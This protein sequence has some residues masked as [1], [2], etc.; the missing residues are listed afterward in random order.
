MSKH[1]L[2]ER[3]LSICGKRYDD[4]EV[5]ALHAEEGLE[6]PP[7]RSTDIYTP[8]RVP[9]KPKGYHV[10]YMGALRRPEIW[11]PK[12]V[13][14]GFANYVQ[15]VELRTPF[16][17]HLPEP[18]VVEMDEARAKELA[19]SS[20]ISPVSGH[21]VYRLLDRGDRSLQVV[22]GPL[23]PRMWLAIDELA[24]NDPRLQQLSHKELTEVHDQA[25][26]L[27]PPPAKSTREFPR[28][29][30][31]K[32]EPLPPVLNELREAFEAWYGQKPRR[33]P[34][35][36]DYI[37]F[38][39]HSQRDVSGWTQNLENEGEFYVF[40]T[41]GQGSGVAFWLVHE[42]PLAEQPVVFLGS[43][44]EGDVRAI[45]KDLPDFLELLSVGLGPYEA[46]YPRDADIPPEPLPSIRA[47][48]NRHF[49]SHVSRSPEEIVKEATEKFGDIADRM[50]EL[51]HTS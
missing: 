6:P 12:P 47:I 13:P 8:A 49:P 19:I 48:L 41:D 4:P 51:N 9:N 26:K 3:L 43:E 29:S 5:I 17:Q 7:P 25:A 32:A 33:I 40:G 14:G 2:F 39:V 16:Q 30:A 23:G 50:L 18:F 11:P 42:A 10:S 37:D 22:V 24:E 36:H 27:A 45:A 1:S 34:G 20:S 35:D 46:P 15:R 38:R 31:P 28:H 44:G 21:T